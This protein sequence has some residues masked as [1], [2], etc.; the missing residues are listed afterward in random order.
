[1]RSTPTS[2]LEVLLILPPLHLF[3]K[4]EARQAANILLGNGCS[5]V[6]ATL[7]TQRSWWK[8]LPRCLYCWLRWTNLWPLIYSVGNFLSI[9]LQG[10]I[11]LEC[12]HLIA[13]DGL[14]SL[15]MDLFARCIR[16]ILWHFE[17]QGIIC[18]W[19]SC[20]YSLSIR[21]ICLFGI[22]HFG[23]HCQQSNINLLW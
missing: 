16:C 7:D 1:M 18:L 2:A 13:P 3:I 8:C 11:S 21:S 15:L 4:Q 6:H 23:G 19:I 20:C 9:Y 10:R 5:Y 22:L 17:C 14:V 12:V